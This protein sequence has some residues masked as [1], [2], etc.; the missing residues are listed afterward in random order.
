MGRAGGSLEER[1]AHAHEQVPHT[2]LVERFEPGPLSGSEDDLTPPH[3]LPLLTGVIPVLDRLRAA[4]PEAEYLFPSPTRE[5][6]WVATA[7]PTARLR[8]RAG[9]EFQLRDIRRTV[10]TR[11]REM[12][13]SQDVSEAILSHARPRLIRT[14]DRYEPVPEMRPALEAWSARLEAILSASPEGRKVIPFKG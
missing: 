3:V 13:T 8:E 12:G 9:V 10:R 6:P 7:I 11:L 1:G 14:Y 2:Q 5:G 4:H